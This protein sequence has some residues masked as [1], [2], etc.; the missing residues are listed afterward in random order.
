MKYDIIKLIF[1]INWNPFFFTIRKS[2]KFNL[3]NL[4]DLLNY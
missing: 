1:E 2:I 3:L 4:N